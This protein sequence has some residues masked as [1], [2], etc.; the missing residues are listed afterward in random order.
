MIIRTL[1]LSAALV[2]GAASTTLAASVAAASAGPSFAYDA[3]VPP[4]LMSVVDLPAPT[5]GVTARK[6]SFGGGARVIDAEEIQ[7]AGPGSHPAVLFV[8]WLGEPSTTNHTEFE[9]DAVALAKQ[10]VTSLLIDAPWSHRG[11]FGPLGG[12]ADADI[13]SSI[14]TVIDLR[15]SLDHLLAMPGVDPK[16]VAFVGHDFG[17]M[18]G[19]LMASADQRPSWYVLMAPNSS[20][21][22]WYLWEKQKPDRAAYLARLAVLDV[23]AFLR[24]AK[25]KGFLLQFSAHDVYITAANAKAIVDAAPRP[26]EVKTYDVDHGLELPAVHAD[27]LAWLRARLLPGS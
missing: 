10:G 2:L 12:D 23:P 6:V 25:A 7:G 20:I 22:E 24:R 1:A 15:R 14:D 18:F 27:R 13:K 11:W 3:S 4:P 16:R 8:H 5:P 9:A 17:A 19:M 26:H 21:G